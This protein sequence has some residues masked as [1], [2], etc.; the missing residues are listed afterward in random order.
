M[1]TR[2][3]YLI[4]LVAAL[5]LWAEASAV[6]AAQRLT[7]T[8]GG[9]SGTF[10]IQGAGLADYINRNSQ[11]LRL[12]PSASGGSTENI[13]R[14]A[15]GQAHMGMAFS[16]DIYD[17]LQGNP[18]FNRP[19]RDFYVLGP[20][21]QLSGWI[22]VVLARSGMYTVEDLKGKRFSPGAPGSGSAS[23]AELFLREAGLAGQMRLAYFSW[24]ELPGLL[25]DGVIDGFNRT[26]AN[27]MPA[28]AEIDITHPVRAL[29]LGPVMDRIGFLEKYPY[30][31]EFVI[32]AGTYRGQDR[33]ARTFG[34]SV[35][36]VVHKNVSDRAVEEFLRLAYTDEAVKFLDTVYKDHAHGLQ[37]P[38]RGLVGPLH[39]V[40]ERF[41]RARGVTV[42]AQPH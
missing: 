31:Q 28:A 23:S 3:R 32:P 36:W 21:Q 13:R 19:L 17:A 6:H 27:P 4:A 38:P 9:T 15:T 2:S 24:G 20:A 37:E 29:D 8:L 39:P 16:G 18:P 41:W 25:K 42:P 34:M 30:F 11:F 14:V 22:F 33:P 7:V 1:R 12:T 5:A 10:Y 40:A 35:W 26:G